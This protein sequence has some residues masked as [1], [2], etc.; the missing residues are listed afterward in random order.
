[1]KSRFVK[2]AKIGAVAGTVVLMLNTLLMLGQLKALDSRLSTNSRLLSE[3]IACEEAMGVKSAGI[4]EMADRFEALLEKMGTA[5]SL[6]RRIAADAEQIKK[7]NDSLLAVNSEIDKVI[8]ENFDMANRIASRMSGVVN[9][10]NGAGDIL[11]SIGESARGQL[12]KVAQMY[13]LACE[14]NAALPA[15]P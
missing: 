7:M 1:M 15:L 13:D 4:Q 14:N 11:T 3:A 6:A 9:L 10:M 8:V 12:R 2:Y 5:R